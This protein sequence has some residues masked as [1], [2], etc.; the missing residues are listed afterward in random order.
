[1]R[2]TSV[3]IGTIVTA[4]CLFVL[5]SCSTSLGQPPND[6]KPLNQDRPSTATT[7]DSPPSVFSGPQIGEPLHDFA[8][9]ELKEN[10]QPETFTVSDAP[11]LLI[12]MHQRTR[13]A[14]AVVRTLAEFTAKLEKSDGERVKANR[15][16]SESPKLRTAIVFLTRDKSQ[17]E[18]WW[19]AVA[20]Y[21]PP[22]TVA[23]YSTDGDEG[24]GIYGL[25]REVTLTILLAR[26]KKVVANFAL[27]D[28]SVQVD[29]PKIIR[30]LGLLLNLDSTTLRNFLA[31]ATSRGEMGNR[32]GNAENGETAN[33]DAR[34]RRLLVPLI[35]LNNTPD[36]VETAAKK[37]IDAV[38]NDPKLKTEIG[39]RARR[40]VDAGVIEKYGIAEAQTYLKEW[41]KT[42]Q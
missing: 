30:E 34:V 25:N 6:F 18:Q 9:Q 28:P 39:T 10:Q 41:A 27:I 36:E 3:A 24:P 19:K 23:G 4:S 26:N 32:S 17:T 12:F 35:Q 40:L 31:E 21:F 37:I 2:P 7:E 42:W 20:N 13:P 38:A 16:Q 29:A 22:K 15:D 11:T 5:T 33:M 8:F 1:M 14:F